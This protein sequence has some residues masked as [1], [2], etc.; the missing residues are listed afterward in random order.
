MSKSKQTVKLTARLI[1]DLAAASPEGYFPLSA[2][3]RYLTDGE[4][5]DL[6][7]EAQSAGSIGI[8]GDYLYD[9]HRLSAEEVRQRCQLFVGSFPSLRPDGLPASRSI[10]Q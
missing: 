3:Q 6:L 1:S 9:T 7:T 5:A 10:E 2:L 4:L 8:E